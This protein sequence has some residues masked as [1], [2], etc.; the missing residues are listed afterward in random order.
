MK[1]N[2]T[3]ITDKIVEMFATIATTGASLPGSNI[4]PP[5]QSAPDAKS[6]PASSELNRKSNSL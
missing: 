2:M 3:A 6:E 5:A 1:G 4:R